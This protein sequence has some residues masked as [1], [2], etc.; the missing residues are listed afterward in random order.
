MNGNKLF[1]TALSLPV[2]ALSNIGVWDCNRAAGKG[3]WA[4]APNPSVDFH[5]NSRKPPQSTH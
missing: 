5:A 4:I 2:K 1:D 3:K